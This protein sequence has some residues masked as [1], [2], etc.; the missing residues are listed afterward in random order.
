MKMVERMAKSR[1]KKGKNFPQAQR[2]LFAPLVPWQT[3]KYEVSK[4]EANCQLT[5]FYWGKVFSYK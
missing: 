2:N 5:H 4:R 1:V 3:A